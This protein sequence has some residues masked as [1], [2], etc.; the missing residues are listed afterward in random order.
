[1][2]M[3]QFIKSELAL[4]SPQYHGVVEEDQ[5]TVPVNIFFFFL[6]ILA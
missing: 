4:L 1:M 5:S 2:L 3:D 6:F